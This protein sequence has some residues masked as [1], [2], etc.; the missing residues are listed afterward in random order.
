M[1]TESAD[2]DQFMKQRREVAQ[3]YVTGDAGPLTAISAGDDPATF[4]SPMGGYVEGA[5]AVVSTNERGAEQFQPGGDTDLE[6]LHQGASGDLAYW[7]GVQH[8]KVLMGD[9]SEPVPMALRIT[10]VFRHEDGGWKLVHR[11]A[12]TQASAPDGGK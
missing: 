2:F 6:V 1:R 9:S 12:D 11:H 10:E 8:A 4:F 3:A 7:V 5:A